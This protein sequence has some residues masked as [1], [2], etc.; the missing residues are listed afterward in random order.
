MPE[1]RSAL[2]LLLQGVL[3]LLRGLKLLVS[4][5]T[6]AAGRE[7]NHGNN[8]SLC[9]VTLSKHL[10]D[11]GGEDCVDKRLLCMEMNGLDDS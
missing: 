11:A 3:L 7:R 10:L 4:E 9:P 2:D 1:G 6:T 8:Q 5:M